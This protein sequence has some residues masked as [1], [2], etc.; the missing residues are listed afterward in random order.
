MKIHQNLILVIF[1]SNAEKCKLIKSFD[2]F[3]L[4]QIN[5]AACRFSALLPFL[6]ILSPYSFLSP[7]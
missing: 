3:T 6:I 5:S 2:L 1:S 7:L 4:H